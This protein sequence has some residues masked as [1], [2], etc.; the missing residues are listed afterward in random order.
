MYGILEE[1]NSAHFYVFANRM[2]PNKFQIM[3]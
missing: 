3:I 1:A 2:Y